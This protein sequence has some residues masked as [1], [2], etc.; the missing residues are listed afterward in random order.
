MFFLDNENKSGLNRPK[1]LFTTIITTK[2]TVL[3]ANSRQQTKHS[4]ALKEEP[5]QPELDPS[6]S[7]ASECSILICS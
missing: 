2:K 4:K 5:P 3:A 1:G 7:D 6:P